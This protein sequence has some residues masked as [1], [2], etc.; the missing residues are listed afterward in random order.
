[1]KIFL[2]K[3]RKEE[4]KLV[5]SIVWEISILW[6]APLSPPG[7]GEKMIK[8]NIIGPHPFREA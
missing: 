6:G 2:G 1:L 8:G 7:G 3:K 5:W 4:K